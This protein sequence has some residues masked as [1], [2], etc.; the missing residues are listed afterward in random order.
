MNKTIN[1]VYPDYIKYLEL[2]NK[3]TTNKNIEYKFKNYILPFFKDFKIKNVNTQ[4]YIDFQLY[5]KKFDFS[6]SFYEQIHIICKRFF[7]YL[8]MMYDVENIPAKVGITKRDTVYTSNQKKGT[9]TKR[10]FN[11][12]IRCV[13]NNVYHA[14]FNVLFYCGLRKGEILAL[15]IKDFKKNCLIINKTITKELYNGKRQILKPKTTKSNR[16]IKLD[17][18]TQ[19]EL[20]KLIKYYSTH[21]SNFNDNFYLFGGDKPISCTTL[22]RKKN[23]YCKKAKV[24]Q[25][26]IHDF[27]HSHATLLYNKNVK[28][29]LIQERLGHSNVN[30]TLDTYVHTNEKQQK[31]LIKKINLIRL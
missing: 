22:E 23:E 7:D 12:F 14:L 6:N 20:K 9:F 27:R 24:K 16:V 5:I 17:L 30:I 21:Y 26:R 11:K 3:M 1:E 10:E 31:K 2:K 19:Y 25:I 8:N 28:I 13:D 15:T 29:K 4:T 18:L